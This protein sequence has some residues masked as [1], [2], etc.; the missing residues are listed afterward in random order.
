[1]RAL[2]T[3]ALA[4]TIVVGGLAAT[5]TGALADDADRAPSRQ[6]VER[7][8]RAVTDRAG[9]VA[10]VRARLAVVQHEADRA[11]V[12]AGRAAEAW[13]GARWRAA[14]ARRDVRRAERRATAAGR[15]LDRQQRA[16]SGAVTASYQLSPSLNALTAL[17]SEGGIEGVLGR[18]ATVR[19][20]AD[21]LEGR[22]DE[23]RAAVT[24]AEVAGDQAQRARD[25]ADAAAE[26]AREARDA[27][28]ASAA[29]A[30]T[31]ARDVAT[32]RD[33]LVA[34][35]ARLQG[36]ST[37]LAAQRQ[38]ALEQRA[39]EAAAQAAADAAAA[40]A[41]AEQEEPPA[42]EQAPATPPEP[43]PTQQPQ[44][45]PT[46]EPTGEPAPTQQPEPT[47]EP[48]PSQESD[49]TPAPAAGG[50]QAAIAFA[51]AQ[52]GEP[53]R[54]GAA[55]PSAWDCSGLTAGAWA[56]GGRSLPHYSVAQYEQST[57]ISADGL[58]PG[59][60]VFWSDGGPSSIY[61]VALY[62]GAGRIIHAPRTGR[63]VVEESM[64]AWAPDLFARP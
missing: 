11:A 36:T 14:E 37:E 63:P 18:S 24:L 6:Q 54:W 61:H 16:Y 15:D 43:A 50:A 44:P 59:D 9:D 12:E 21:A 56:E 40:A 7:A 58:R 49:S 51:R 20:A 1:M 33:A 64:W 10:A 19:N 4:L 31:A 47:P 23:F 2:G 32:E 52:L 3:A 38:A 26:Q 13:N 39:Q 29:S 34:D 57:P 60:L 55:G 28:A 45:E 42:P 25:E 46:Q 22:Y 48:A 17:T 62:T 8:E 35:L 27:A 41:A 30:E 53:Y 5:G